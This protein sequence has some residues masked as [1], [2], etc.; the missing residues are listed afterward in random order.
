MNKKILITGATDGIGLETAKMLA[1]KGQNIIVHGRSKDKVESVKNILEE[2]N[3]KI[4]IKS[5]VADLSELNQVREMAETLL[6][7]RCEIDVL[8]NNAGVFVVSNTKTKDNLETRFVVNTIAPYLLTK[9]LLPIIKKDGRIIN[10]SSAAQSPVDFSALKEWKPMSHDEAYAQSKL[11]ITMWSMEL[12][13]EYK[14]G[15]SILA[16]NPKSFLGSKMVKEAYKTQGHDLRI[17]ADLLTRMAISEEFEGIT[18]KY[19]DNDF[20]HFDNPHPD[21]L[22]DYNRS[23]L[24]RIMDEILEDK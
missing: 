9:L 15:P 7:E 19:Y 2:I 23:E 22:D 10:L 21:A 11:A 13:N 24:I 6:K 12:A 3:N 8:I 18:G 16:V 1:E 4:E 14:D 5:I 20:G 17:G